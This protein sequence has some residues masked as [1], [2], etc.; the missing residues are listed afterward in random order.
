[1]VKIKKYDSKRANYHLGHRFEDLKNI[2]EIQLKQGDCLHTNDYM[3]G[4]ANGLILAWH[5]MAEPYGC[6]VEYI[7]ES[8]AADS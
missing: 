3:R 2:L 6:E 8:D 1:M 7:E 4:M 5:T